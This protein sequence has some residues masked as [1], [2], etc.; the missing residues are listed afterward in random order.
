MIQVTDSEG[1]MGINISWIPRSQA[2]HQWVI[3]GNQG[4]PLNYIQFTVP[5]FECWEGC[6]GLTLT[7][8]PWWQDLSDLYIKRKSSISSS[9]S[10]GPP[11]SR[12]LWTIDLVCLY[13]VSPAN[14]A[15]E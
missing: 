7:V 3:K 15:F 10:L 14:K 11:S 1:N 13:A 9:C 2:N 8:I 5:R 4:R 12:S 6:Y